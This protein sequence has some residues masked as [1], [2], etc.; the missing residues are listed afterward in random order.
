MFNICRC[1]LLWQQERQLQ[2]QLSSGDTVW[3]MDITAAMR[4][5]VLYEGQAQFSEREYWVPRLT[6]AERRTIDYYINKEFEYSDNVIEKYAKWMYHVEK[7]EK[8]FAIYSTADHNNPKLLYAKVGDKA[9][10]EMKVLKGIADGYNRADSNRGSF[11]LWL[12]NFAVQQTANDYRNVRP[13][14]LSETG[15]DAAL[16]DAKRQYRNT[17][18]A[19]RN[20]LRNLEDLRLREPIR[21]LRPDEQFVSRGQVIKKAVTISDKT[22]AYSDVIKGLKK[23]GETRFGTPNEIPKGVL[24]RAAGTGE[25]IALARSG[26]GR[27]YAYATCKIGKPVW[28]TKEQWNTPEWRERTQVPEG[29]MYDIGNADGK[30]FFPFEEIEILNEEVKPKG[31]FPGGAVFS[32]RDDNQKTDTQVLEEAAKSGNSAKMP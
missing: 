6:K 23:L 25:R 12:E 15:R 24:S 32:E 28:V 21:T 26:V 18:K 16:D 29:D 31:Y 3:S 1:R 11:N 2:S 17:S 19:F 5:S 8:Y 30:W 27:A 7:G 9:E 4:Q 14:Y 13:K 10:T 22:F 20:C